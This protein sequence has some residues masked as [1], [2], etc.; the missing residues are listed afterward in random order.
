MCTN[1]FL[2]EDIVL[3]FDVPYFYTKVKNKAERILIT[4][5]NGMKL[6]NEL[7]A[8]KLSAAIF[9]WKQG[10]HEFDELY[11]DIIGQCPDF[12]IL[13][14]K[15]SARKDYR[16]WIFQHKSWSFSSSHVTENGNINENSIAIFVGRFGENKGAVQCAQMHF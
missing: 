6:A 14:A 12:A 1:A 3:I 8:P 16:S 2:S 13:A 10:E 5:I 11:S 15:T 4:M 9:L 7:K